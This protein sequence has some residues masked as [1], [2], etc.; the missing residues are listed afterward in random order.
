MLFRSFGYAQLVEMTLNEPD[1]ARNNLKLLVKGAQRASDLVQQILTFSR[2][3]EHK[4][5]PLKLF[6]IV[7]ESVKF[8]R[9]SIPATIEIQ[10]NITSRA[11]VLADPTEIHQVVINLCTNAYH[12][13]RDS[14]GILF[15]ALNDVEITP[16]SHPVAGSVIPG[17]YLKLEV[18][19]TGH[20]MDTK[21]MEKIFNPY[22]TTHKKGRGTGLGLAIV[23]RIIKNHNGFIKTDSK[24]GRGSTFQVFWPVIEQ[25]ENYNL[26]EKKGELPKGTEQIMLVDDETDILDTSQAVLE[27]IGY[28][29]AIFKNGLSAL[30]AFIK[31][32]NFF[33]LIVTDMT[34]PGKIGRA[35]V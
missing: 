20:G 14:G 31:R 32:P 33:D 29:V 27:R 8:L 17:H 30:Q 19:D 15:V 26:S 16:Q 7:K 4:K 13:M 11:M 21:I 22:F 5:N 28:K 12:A 2:Q 1:Q 23:D 35:H 9:S 3:T 10:E 34:M 18:R 24:V 6:I 25:K